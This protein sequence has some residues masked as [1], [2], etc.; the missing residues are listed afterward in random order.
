MFLDGKEK[1]LKSLGLILI[2]ILAYFVIYKIIHR[3][4]YHFIVEYTDVPAISDNLNI[5]KIDV[6]FR[7]YDVG[8]VTKIKLAEDQSHI[9]FY[10]NINY[11]GLRIPT[12]SNIIF[13]TENLYG[14]RYLDVEPP[15][16]PSGKLIADGDIIN[17]LEA[18]ER[19]DEYFLEE[20][21]TGQTGILISNLRD[22]TD[23]LK[24]SLQDK[25]NKKLLNQSSGDLA[26]ILENLRQITEDPG[27]ERN[28]KSTIK[29]SAGSL[30]SI[31]EI[32]RKK[33]MRKTIEESP[34]SIKKTLNNIETMN[35]HLVKVSGVIPEATKNM[36]TA[37][38][39]I[40]EAN[41]T[42]GAINKKVPPIPPSL[43][44]NTEKLVVKTD[45]FETEISKL[46]S[47]R[48]ALL[49]LVFGNPGQ[50]FKNCSHRACSKE[51]KTRK[52]QEKKE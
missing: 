26:I 38:G 20:I 17:G 15:Q 42:L 37:N 10:V 11:K 8:D 48:A 51:Q 35:E 43:V 19:L 31:D 52:L 1:Y 33:E 16:V 47:K 46:L 34:E 6:H 50:S 3:P 30:K 22:I 2:I 40:S 39:L 9:E 23:I 29:H 4:Q 5:F 27:F 45:C 12:N 7:G 25:E 21:K 13:K 14:T 32:L 24:I 18:Y 28:I 41:D 49:R 36:A 44:E